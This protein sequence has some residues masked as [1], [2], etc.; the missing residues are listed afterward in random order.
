MDGPR[1]TGGVHRRRPLKW[2]GDIFASRCP[3]VQSTYVK[4]VVFS[5]FKCIAFFYIEMKWR[6]GVGLVSEGVVSAKSDP[7]MHVVYC[8]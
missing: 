7:F 5:R 4:Y 1:G 3:V 6:V 2:G 8:S